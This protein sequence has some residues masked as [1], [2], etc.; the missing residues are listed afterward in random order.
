MIGRNKGGF[1]LP[2]TLVLACGTAVWMAYNLLSNPA[3]ESGPNG[4][5]ASKLPEIGGLRAEMAYAMPPM[6]S[7][8]AILTRPIFSPSRRPVAG[9]APTVEVAARDL[10]AK[11]IGQV[12]TETEIRVAL[13]P[14]DGG[15]TVNL[16]Q[17]EDYRGWT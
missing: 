2:A 9:A 16:R 12:G 17:G 6:E 11:L 10:G 5:A 1:L 3:A 4:G 13:K 7:F 14:E 15:E 8:D